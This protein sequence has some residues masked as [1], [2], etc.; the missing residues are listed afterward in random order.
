MAKI[1]CLKCGKVIQSESVHDFVMCGCDNKTFIDGGD[2]YCR[3][4][5]LDMNLVELILM[6]EVEMEDDEYFSDPSKYFP[7]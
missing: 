4:G 1:K 6:P 2:K 5:G 3:F 7:A